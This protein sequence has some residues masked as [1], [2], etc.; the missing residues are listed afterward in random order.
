MLDVLVRSL[1]V[2]T[3]VNDRNLQNCGFVYCMEPALKRIYPDRK[4]FLERLRSYFEY[5]ASNPFFFPVILGLCVHLERK[6]KSDMIQKLKIE[7]MSP[8]AALSD[9][10]IWGT[11]KPF[12]TVFCGVAALMG[13]PAGPFWFWFLFVV[14]TNFFRIYTFYAGLRMG[15][16][17]IYHL[18]KLRLQSLIGVMKKSS[19][20]F[21]GGA[22]FLLLYRVFPVLQRGQNEYGFAGLILAAYF[23]VNA[24]VLSKMRRE[25]NFLVFIAVFVLFYYIRGAQVAP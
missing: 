14:Q 15:L 13:S 2:N 5:F 6:G 7:T 11:L 17:V 9:A 22:S 18:P 23:V 16:G 3:L 1:F 21:F 25:V 19:V 10:M 8:I 24:L 20:I 4:V 12:L